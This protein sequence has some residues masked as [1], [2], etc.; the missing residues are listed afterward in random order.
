LEENGPR[1][2]AHAHRDRDIAYSLARAGN[3]VQTN[4]PGL[5]GPELD[6][7]YARGAAWLDGKPL[8]IP[9]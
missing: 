9:S 3:K 6:T 8:E 7:V 1:A 5:D 2:N 4:M